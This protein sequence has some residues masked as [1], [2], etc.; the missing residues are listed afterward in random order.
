[1]REA[2]NP[3]IAIGGEGRTMIEYEV[4]QLLPIEPGWKFWYVVDDDGIQLSS[5]PITAQ[6]IVLGSGYL[7]DDGGNTEMETKVD[8]IVFDDGSLKTYS[9]ARSY[10]YDAINTYPVG[11]TPPNEPFTMDSAQVVNAIR[12]LEGK[13]KLRRAAPLEG[14]RA[15]SRIHVEKQMKEAVLDL[16]YRGKVEIKEDSD[17]EPI[18]Q[19][20]K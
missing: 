18:I 8:F 5:C 13:P 11:V 9:E 19:T 4:K 2:S 12:A 14:L 17:G 1:M 15:A 16:F 10:A 3:V 7:D 20:V 6:A